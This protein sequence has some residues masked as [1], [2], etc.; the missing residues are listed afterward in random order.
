[1]R[2]TGQSVPT[3]YGAKEY[4]LAIVQVFA[5]GLNISG[6][7]SMQDYFFGGGGGGGN[8]DA[9]KGY[10]RASVHPLKSRTFLIKF[11]TYLTHYTLN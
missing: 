10:M 1:M 3:Q 6:F 7:Q 11:R 8:V 5:T 4:S 9:C 2:H